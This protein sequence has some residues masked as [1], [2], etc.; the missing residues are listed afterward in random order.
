MSS[1]E[2]LSLS[3]VLGRLMLQTGRLV[4]HTVFWPLDFK[5]QKLSSV[6]TT[7]S[8]T[9][10]AKCSQVKTFSSIF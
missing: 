3:R 9:R 10:Q 6:E 4:L 1:M 2:H 8:A 5:C 7:V